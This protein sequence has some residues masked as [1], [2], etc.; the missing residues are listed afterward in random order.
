MDAYVQLVK[1]LYP[2]NKGFAEHISTYVKMELALAKR[3]I[4]S[5]LLQYHDL[6]KLY[7]TRFSDLVAHIETM[8]SLK[9]VEMESSIK[10]S[11]ISM[12]K[13]TIAQLS[14]ADFDKEYLDNTIKI[15]VDVLTSEDTEHCLSTLPTALVIPLSA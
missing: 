4:C 15:L 6:Q 9:I 7:Q 14:A 10:Q 1:S 12:L 3:Q 13:I 5:D 11:E 8:V 2:D